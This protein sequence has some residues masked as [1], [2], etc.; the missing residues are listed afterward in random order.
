MVNPREVKAKAQRLEEQNYK[1]RTFLKN[2]ADD[3]ELDAQFLALH[4][5]LFDGYD[6]CKCANCCKAYSIVLDNDEV[7]RTASFLGLSESDFVAE[8]LIDAGA[9]D[10]KPYKFKEKPCLFLCDDGR[11]RIQD[12]KPDACAG[13]PFTDQPDRLSSMYGVIEHA[14]VCPIVFEILERLKAMY[15]FRNR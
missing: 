8:Y 15:K 12:C 7:K 9:D 6:C 1:F 4:K 5:E 13:Y 11:C 14:E 3:D 10:E 2:R